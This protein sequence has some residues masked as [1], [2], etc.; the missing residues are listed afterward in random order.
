MKPTVQ[1]ERVLLYNLP[2]SID[3][4]ARIRR[5]LVGLGIQIIDITPD[6]LA[7]TL[8]YCAGISGYGPSGQ[9]Y[10]GEPFSEDV[11]I[12]AALSDEKINQLLAQIRKSGAG[13]VSLMAVVTEHNRSW[14]LAR[15]FAELRSERQVMAAWIS[16]QQ[17]VKMA[18]A[19]EASG[20]RP[21]AGSGSP[22]MTFESALATARGVLQSEE[23]PD[24]TA[25]R[26]A[27]LDLK[28]FL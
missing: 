14:P 23:P 13:S 26:Q 22:G 11:M 24:V 15:L 5:I 9:S 28:A 19:L 17:S 4:G 1:R 21:A 6:K 3:K 12:L 16:L 7:Q 10:E 25:I 2:A 18:E 27:D 20:A 8:G